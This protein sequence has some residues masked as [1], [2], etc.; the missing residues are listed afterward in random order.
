[1]NINQS[2]AQLRQ[3]NES[4]LFTSPFS[5]AHSYLRPFYEVNLCALLVL[6]VTQSL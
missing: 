2:K 4:D 1:M 3:R 5:E 6:L